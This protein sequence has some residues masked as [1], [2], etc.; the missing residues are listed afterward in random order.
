MALDVN[1]RSL[2]RQFVMFLCILGLPSSGLAC[3][4][5]DQA[6]SKPFLEELSASKHI[7]LVRVES[8][9]LLQEPSD[10][11][12]F[13]NI[14]ATIRIVDVLF[15]SRPQLNSISYYSHWCGGHRLDTGGYYVV[16]LRRDQEMLKLPFGGQLVAGLGDEYSE[17]IGDRGAS[18]LLM[19]LRNFSKGAELPAAFD[20]RPYLDLVRMPSQ[21][22]SSE[23]DRR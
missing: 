7:V 19:Y 1:V 15:G 16:L 21:E 14:V 13:R 17:P 5:P 8:Q 3:S 22:P 10:D 6:D 23:V 12:S 9:R 2:A 20:T 11:S 18:T 4:S